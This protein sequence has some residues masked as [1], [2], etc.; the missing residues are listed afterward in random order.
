MGIDVEAL[1][2]EAALREDERRTEKTH[3]HCLCWQLLLWYSG[4]FALL[5]FRSRSVPGL[6]RTL[7]DWLHECWHALRP[8]ELPSLW[9]HSL[10]DGADARAWT[11]CCSLYC[12][13]P[14]GTDSSMASR[15]ARLCFPLQ[16]ALQ[17]PQGGDC[18]S[19]HPHPHGFVLARARGLDWPSLNDA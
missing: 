16:R 2:A 14:C 17:R 15:R 11:L 6:L 3:I 9:A 4:L 7:L 18:G 5:P 1:D 10:R 8:V 19:S 13:W 12:G